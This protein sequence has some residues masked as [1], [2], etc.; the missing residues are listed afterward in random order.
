[1]PGTPLLTATIVEKWV[2]RNPIGLEM[3]PMVTAE[4]TPS[5]EREFSALRLV[6][7]VLSARA[8]DVEA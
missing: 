7:T 4:Y 2:G 5:I 1:M 8:R 6:G 3:V